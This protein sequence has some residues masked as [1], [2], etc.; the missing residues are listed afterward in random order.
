M[1][2]K[3]A[4]TKKYLFSFFAI[5]L[6]GG[7]FIG[8]LFLFNSRLLAYGLR[9]ADIKVGGLD[10]QSA[11][12]LM[13]DAAQEWL[14]QTINLQFQGQSVNVSLGSLGVQLDI[15]QNI[16]RAEKIG[17]GRNFFQNIKEQTIALFGKYNLPLKV[18]ID[19]KSLDNF[20]E[21]YFQNHIKASKNASLSYQ[22]GKIILSPSSAGYGP[23]WSQL[24]KEIKQKAAY[25]RKVSREYSLPVRTI[26][27]EIKD[28]E[29]R[30]AQQKAWEILSIAPYEIKAG[31]NSWQ[32]LESIIGKSLKFKAVFEQNSNNYV[33]GLSLDKAPLTAYLLNILPQINKPPINA[34]LDFQDGQIVIRKK[35][36]QGTHL[37][38][39]ESVDNIIKGLLEGEQSIS[40]SLE[41]T[42]A[43]VSKETLQE[44]GIDTLIGKGESDF[45]GS[46]LSRVNNIEVGA[47]KFDE[48]LIKPGEEFSFN[49]T[50][51]EISGE[52]GYLPGL[53]I[54]NHKL[55]PEFGG[56]ICQV[57]TTM[58][59]TAVNA[60]LKITERYP[61]SFA[62]RFYN[63]QGFDATVYPPHPDLRFVNNTNGYILIQRKIENDH[64]IFEMYGKNDGRTVKVKGPYIYEKNDDGSMK[65][66]LWQEVY[67]KDGKLLFK[68]GFWSY[69][70]SPETYPVERN[71]LE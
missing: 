55:V 22:D 28:D 18:Q 64:L 8:A 43:A 13:E 19:N 7:I 60:G 10:T 14:S 35:A 70:K 59:R 61:H 12:N 46:S 39:D 38:I 52:A 4:T 66:V 53:V 40:L 26:L 29:T 58:F 42:P 25:L 17:H 23:G 69:Y 71:P 1:A 56:G 50:L 45:S 16:R 44:L 20:S 2:Q 32:I 3:A 62:V 47:Q 36:E 31:S 67:D 33:L 68:K 49:E 21:I 41:E 27:P 37:L 9:L 48:Y 5:C 51:G 65:T 63:P 24:I 15:A 57:S 6:V 11:F 34:R 30:Q 54:K